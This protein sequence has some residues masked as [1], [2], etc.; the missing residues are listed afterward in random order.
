[1]NRIRITNIY[2]GLAALI[3]IVSVLLI[4]SAVGTYNSISNMQDATNEYITGQ[5]A[6][7][8]MREASDYLTE[9]ARAFV[10]TGD[11]SHAENY[12]QEISG[13]M[14][15]EKAVE[16]ALEFG[17]EKSIADSLKSALDDSNSLAKVEVYAMR[18]AAEGY[19]TDPR[20]TDPLFED[21]TLD[22]ADEELTGAEMIGK[23]TA[24]LFNEE[25]SS[26]K[27]SIV[28][29][30]I[31][32]LDSL[33][34]ETRARQI[35]SYDVASSY[36]KRE[37]AMIVLIMVLILFTLLITARLII[38]PITRSAKV[39]AAH[40]PLPLKGSAEYVYLAEAYNSMLD[41]TKKNEEE[42]SY[43]AT[44]DPLT[45][46]YNRKA[47]ET[48]QEKFGGTDLAMLLID[49]DHFKDVNDN[50]GHDVG[51][52]VL[53]K[54]ADAL[55]SSFRLEDYV[56]RIGGD[57]FAVIMVQMKPELM[58][59]VK[60]KISQVRSKIAAKDDLPEVTVSVGAAFSGDGGT[61]GVFKKADM[62]LYKT[63]EK[64]RNGYTFYSDI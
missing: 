8:S 26:M 42:L 62:A 38:I 20:E 57:E 9:E 4:S 24:M 60:L 32:G 5:D 27:E 2:R 29:D 56:C 46:L 50:N 39:I 34:E 44:H 6:I 19:G 25:Y 37:F 51:D 3:V 59:V 15:R 40:D 13:N 49:V 55:S 17:P 48:A 45:G 63:K 43:E 36:S 33:L 1:M 11:V 7:N 21:I 22:P 10:V 64:G 28:S 53:K 31:S 14:R 47:F 52:A 58:N 41:K 35:E 12:Y 30:V 16:A 23:A 54:V 61:E 18:L